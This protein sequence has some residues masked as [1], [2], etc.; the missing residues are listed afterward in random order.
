VEGVETA[1]R[2]GEVTGS[3][4]ESNAERTHGRALASETQASIQDNLIR[5][6]PGDLL[7]VF[8]IQVFG[9]LAF[10]GNTCWGR[11]GRR[12]AWRTESFDRS[13]G[14]TSEE[15]VVAVPTGGSLGLLRWVGRGIVVADNLFRTDEWIPLILESVS[16]GSVH[17]NVGQAPIVLRASAGG[18]QTPHNVP[19]AVTL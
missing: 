18:V 2:G 8:R 6:R 11:T 17:G 9:Q 16:Y 4:L 15:R 19:P 5:A 7:H 13:N 3:P 10:T 14:P 1:R 12:G